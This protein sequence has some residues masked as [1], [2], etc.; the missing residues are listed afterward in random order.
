MTVATLFSYLLFPATVAGILTLLVKGLYPTPARVNAT[1][2]AHKRPEKLQ[3]LVR[4]WF[5]VMITLYLAVQVMRVPMLLDGLERFQTSAALSPPFVS[6]MRIGGI[7][8]ILICEL[9]VAVSW[10]M[11][12]WYTWLGVSRYRI[13]EARPLGPNSP[14]VAIMIAACN[15]EPET[16]RRSLAS[17]AALD[18]PH[19]SVFL[20]EN[21]RSHDYKSAAM[22]LGK[23]YG[24][25]LIDVPNRG[26]KQGAMNDA[27]PFVGSEFVYLVNLDADQRVERNFLKD[28]V[29]LLEQD[30]SLAFVQTP[31]LYDNDEESWLTRAAAQQE[32]LSYDTVMEGKS[33]LGRAMCVGTNFVLR[34]AAL[35]SIG[36]WD[37][38]SL[39]DD[40]I[41]SYLMHGKGWR[42]LYVS[43]AYAHGIGPSNL[44]AYWTQQ[45]RWV[46]G[47]TT[48]AKSI[49][50]ML[51]SRAQKR[52]PRIVMLEYLWSAGY[53]AMTLCLAALAVV[54]MILLLVD[55]LRGAGP[56]V[57][58]DDSPAWIY[59]SV[60]PFYAMVVLFPYLHMRLRGYRI[61]HLL[62]VQGLLA[63]NILLYAGGVL[64]A[65]FTHDMNWEVS[66]KAV[67]PQIKPLWKSPQ[68]YVFFCVLVVGALLTKR[69]LEFPETPF[70]WIALFWLFLYSVTS[71]HFFIYVRNPKGD[72]A[73]DEL[74]TRKDELGTPDRGKLKLEQERAEV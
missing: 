4:G 64:R 3:G 12:L 37:E 17:A 40:M 73:I 1:F 6:A 35:E 48:L 38:T 31:Q 10:S 42:S 49:V 34:R 16:L 65:V 55:L 47:N 15:E 45:R 70:G 8:L 13:P 14:G 44:K 9:V 28:I 20:V 56:G 27:L 19:F 72:V 58:Q 63:T 21:S 7:S 22:A 67:K 29:P 26:H 68:T 62:M 53:Y 33:A 24:A 59:L 39:S 25:T 2:A 18:Y 69:L 5:A 50:T 71:A 36:G 74:G 57:A 30:S 60:M 43:R 46:I 51:F 23:E 52:V 32:M 41:A 54:P 11:Y 66:P 61:R